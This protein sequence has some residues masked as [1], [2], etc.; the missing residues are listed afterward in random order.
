MSSDLFGRKYRV[1]VSEKGTS[2]IDVTGLRC[3][4]TIEKSMSAEPN[5]SVIQIYNLS[6]ATQNSILS[7][8]K[9]VIIEAGYVDSPQFGLIFDGDI[10]K[11]L[12]RGAKG[13]DKIT[14]L[15]AQDG[16]L[17]LNSGF[18][19]VSYSAGQTTQSVLSKMA[20]V[21]DDEIVLGNVSDDLKNTKLARGKVMFGQ[22][23]DYARMLAKTEGALFYV[24]DR[25]IN[26]VKPA[27]LPQG[28]IVDLSPTSGLIGTPEQTETGINAKCLLNPL[29][30][31]NKLVHIR[32]DDVQRSS[33]T[34]STALS[35]GVYKIIKLKHTG[36]TLGNDW[37]TEF[38]GI[39]QP[40]TVP[41]TGAS[42]NN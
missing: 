31:I 33:D 9:R 19:S 27:D 41:L 13:I 1:I 34:A 35:T 21:G 32:N 22:P 4:F 11:S 6:A 40:G 23:K 25:Q 20:G 14:E 10:I 8:G 28:Q 3:V 7:T 30:N 39:A 24:N 2:G 12:K 15:I 29:L 18:I 38:E 5:K 36:D 42:Y 16:D 26:L 17:F 37:Y